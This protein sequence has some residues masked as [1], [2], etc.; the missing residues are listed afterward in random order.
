MFITFRRGVAGYSVLL[1][2]GF[3]LMVQADGVSDNSPP[4]TVEMRSKMNYK[5]KDSY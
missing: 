3:P 1:A 4:I 2:Q 5:S